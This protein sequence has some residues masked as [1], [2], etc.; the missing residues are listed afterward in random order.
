[1]EHTNELETKI[2]IV[3]AGPA[4]TSTALFLTKMGIPHVLIDKA[5]FPRDKICGDGI[6]GKVVGLLKEL[7][8]ELIGKLESR[9]D[10]FLPSWGVRFVAP[11]GKSIDLPFK[12]KGDTSTHAPGFVSKRMDFD[13]FLVDQLNP[14]LT[15]T[16]WNTHIRDVAQNEGHFELS[17]TQNG[18]PFICRAQVVVGAGG[19]QSVVARKLG[20]IQVKDSHLV[21]G[22]RAY[23]ENV[24]ETHPQNFIELH[25]ISEMLP[26][27]LWV[28][29]LPN[30]Q[31]NVG[32]GMLSSALKK[33]KGNLQAI[34]ERALKEN[35]ELSRRFKNARVVQKVTGW[36][37]PL[38]SEQRSI[39][40]NRFLLT[41][42]AGAL[43]DPFTGEGIGNAILS[44]KIAAQTL[45]KAVEKNNF[46][47]EMLKQYDNNLY[48]KLGH[49]LRV[50]YKIQQLVQR[51]WL[52]NF[53]ISRVH[54]NPSLKDTFSAM[55]NDVD[56]R[57]KLRSP[58]FYLRMLVGK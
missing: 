9:P 33:Q 54:N 27:Y 26:G 20:D 45:H 49:E 24:S 57:A 41:G 2:A 52:F 18:Q 1:M 44:G 30:N 31:A 22:L 55:F 15:Q 37:L 50:S 47:A 4:G 43:I 36:R 51:P 28:F 6:S 3:G 42:D 13:A 25:F 29:P 56:M 35:P 14:A 19:T 38:G 8:P 10:Q 16:F 40:G 11:N 53:V 17:G 34:F 48:H 46:S 39:S 23:Y 58:A 12:K 32:I 7:D 5:T 21:A